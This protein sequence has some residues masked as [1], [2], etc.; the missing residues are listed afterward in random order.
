MKYLKLI[1]LIITLGLT[2][3]SVS[4]SS[5]QLP[6]GTKEN[7]TKYI[8]YSISDEFNGKGLDLTKWGR[9]NTG[10]Y[11]V[12]R[13]HADSTLVVMEQ[14]GD[15]KYVS[16]KA[17][18]K[19]GPIRTAGIVSRASGYYGFYVVKFRYRG[20][21]SDDVRTNKSIWHPSVWSGCQDNIDGVKRTT[22][23]G[24][25][26]W[27]EIDFMEWETGPN[28]WSCDA[29]ARFTDSKGKKRKVITKGPGLE[30][31]I[32]NEPVNIMDDR[33]Q[34][35]GLEYSPDHLKIWAWDGNNWN[36]IGER[37]ATFVD[38]D[39]AAPEKSYTIS[40]IG[41]PAR[42]PMFWLLG[43]VVSRYLY[44]KIEDGTS[45]YNKDDLAVDFDYFRYYRHASAEKL[46]WSWENELPNGGGKIQKQKCPVK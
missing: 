34:T 29:P 21:D 27:L 28:G 42:T 10:G 20:F 40:T 3:L 44:P 15:A 37:V 2:Q 33:W 8:D 38:V 17:S 46:D 13:Y 23:K 26:P 41:K 18:A 22:V 11:M 16:I 9:R 6:K 7:Y 19:D 5:Q 25:S 24:K 1:V 32:L 4:Q 14:D 39:E 30:K 12:E 35:I 31:A 45:K 36:H 43:N